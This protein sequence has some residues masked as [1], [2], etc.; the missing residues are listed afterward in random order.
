MRK[1]DK[2]KGKPTKRYGEPQEG[3]ILRQVTR[4]IY[5]DQYDIIAKIGKEEDDRSMSDVMRDLIDIGLKHYNDES[6]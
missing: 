6:D 2:K 5:S 4:D 3:R 1:L